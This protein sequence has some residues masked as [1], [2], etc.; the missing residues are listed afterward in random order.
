VIKC[1]KDVTS[2]IHLFIG[3]YG[4]SNWKQVNFEQIWKKYGHRYDKSNFRENMKRLLIHFQNSTGDFEAAKSQNWY[5]SPT[6]VSEAYSLLL[7][8]YLHPTHWKTLQQM[9]VE[10]IWESDELFQQYSLEEFTTYNENMINLTN[11]K[12]NRIESVEAA[13]RRDM[14]KVERSEKTSKGVYKWHKHIASEL[15]KEDVRNG[16][17][18]SM[19]PKKLWKLRIQY[20]DF[21]LSIFRLHIYQE[22]YKQLAAPYWQI[23][24]NEAAT[25]KRRNESQQMK[26]WL[27]RQVEA[28]V[29]ELIRRMNLL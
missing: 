15:L 2:D 1:L 12:K 3:A 28:D 10:E 8:L 5:T 17:A 24:R 16:T 19:E 18:D 4:K 26:A 27:N 11:K 23:K 22:K 13:F 25:E 7:A 20:R 21:P 14:L 6:N 29:E 9:T